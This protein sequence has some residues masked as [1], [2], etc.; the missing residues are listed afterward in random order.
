MNY[1]A[2][3]FTASR[4]D[5]FTSYNADYETSA[6]NFVCNRSTRW[7]YTTGFTECLFFRSKQTLGLTAYCYRRVHVH[8]RLL[9]K[10][11]RKCCHLHHLEAFNSDPDVN[12]SSEQ[13]ENPYIKIQGNYR[14]L[15]CLWMFRS[16][17]LYDEI[18]TV[19]LPAREILLR[20]V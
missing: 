2:C 14:A 13:D 8:W 9:H 7:R 3:Y 1:A 5:R 11:M 17:R 18:N 6:F 19:S 20:D 4:L 12:T 10:L 15:I 16:R